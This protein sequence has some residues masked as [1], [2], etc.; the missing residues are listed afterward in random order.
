MFKSKYSTV[1]TV[2]L[3]VLIIVIV[4]IAIVFGV[5]TYKNYVDEKDRKAYAELDT[6]PV[7]DDDKDDK[8]NE[9]DEDQNQTQ[10]NPISPMNPI[11][12]NTTNGGG[13]GNRPTPNLPKVKFYKEYPTIGN[14]NIPK[15]G[16]SCPILLDTS[17]KALD[18]AVG[19]TYPS[20]PTLNKPGNVV[21]IGHNYRNG[22]F[23]SN[24]KQLAL[25][26]VIK[27]S[28]L[29]GTTLTYKIYEIFETTPTDTAYMTKDRGENIE[30]SLSTCTDD[31]NNRLVILA[32]VEE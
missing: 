24:N 7:F 4:I 5:K 2:M 26:D 28:D 25:G 8:K 12:N 17:T 10:I 32:R 30:I 13:T 9:V 31:G 23:F 1:L 27:I 16:V 20:S 11:S 14:I 22:K 29:D 3:I 21:I 19:I 18:L 15:T 6:P